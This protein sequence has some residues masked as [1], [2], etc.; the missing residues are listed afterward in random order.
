MR[1]N[2]SIQGWYHCLPKVIHQP[3]MAGRKKVNTNH[4]KQN[5]AVDIHI[6]S[7]QFCRWTDMVMIIWVNRKRLP[8]DYLVRQ[9]YSDLFATLS[10]PHIPP[11]SCGSVYPATA[12]GRKSLS[13][14]ATAELVSKWIATNEWTVVVLFGLLSFPSGCNGKHR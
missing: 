14:N 9:K 11:I 10:L 5:Q 6:T 1:M 2:Q 8:A 13:Q 7:M 3:M 4:Q 12:P